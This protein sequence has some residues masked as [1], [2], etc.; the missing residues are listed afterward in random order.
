MS[1]SFI[2]LKTGVNPHRLGLLSDLLQ[3]FPQD[4]GAMEKD[5]HIDTDLFKLFL[6]SEAYLEY[7]REYLSE[8]Q[9]DS[10]HIP[11]YLDTK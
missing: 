10:V 11:Q 9:I 5:R 3:N 4:L 8:D 1:F 2:R 6:S 7:A